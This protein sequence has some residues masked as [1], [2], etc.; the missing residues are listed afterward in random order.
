MDTPQSLY[1]HVGTPPSY[2]P[3]TDSLEDS[4]MGPVFAAMGSRNPSSL[5]AFESPRLRMGGAAMASVGGEEV[6]EG[7][8]EG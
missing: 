4:I 3:V 1:M 2:N 6:V 8:G 5:P 7:G